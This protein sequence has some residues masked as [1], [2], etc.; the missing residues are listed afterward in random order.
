MFIWDEMRNLNISRSDF[1]LV[2]PFKQIDLQWRKSCWIGERLKIPARCC[3]LIASN[4]FHS[5]AKIQNKRNDK[6]LSKTNA[7]ISKRPVHFRFPS[8][9]ADDLIDRS[10]IQSDSSELFSRES[11]TW[12]QL[13]SEYYICEAARVTSADRT[14]ER[15]RAAIRFLSFD[16]TRTRVTWSP[17]DRRETAAAT[18]LTARS[19]RSGLIERVTRLHGRNRHARSRRAVRKRG[20]LQRR[21]TAAAALLHYA[22]VSP[23]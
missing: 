6:F 11:S 22:Y 21:S 17:T 3:I 5:R 18:L 20:D 10:G 7:W 9:S 15:F 1:H 13:Q 14:P 12:R 4:G 23:V 16:Q 2:F 8:D 19:A